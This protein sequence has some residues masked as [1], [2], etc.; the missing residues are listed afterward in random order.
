[1]LG[2]EGARCLCAVIEHVTDD[3]AVSVDSSHHL[4]DRLRA[5]D[6]IVE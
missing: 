5:S 6:D 1:M 3:G 2:A 4:D